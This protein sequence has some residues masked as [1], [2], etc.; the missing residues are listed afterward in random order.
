MCEYMWWID[1]EEKLFCVKCGQ[2]AEPKYLTKYFKSKKEKPPPRANVC[3]P[4][5]II[6]R[7]IT[8][9]ND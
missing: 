3:S 8:R 4:N 1:G 6:P 5:H 7:T 9:G 2:A